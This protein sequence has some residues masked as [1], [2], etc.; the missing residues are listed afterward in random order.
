M[1]MDPNPPSFNIPF[2]VPPM[3]IGAGYAEGIEQA[4][5]S[6]AGAVGGVFDV[7][8]RNRT[9]NDTLQ[10]MN[11][12]GILSNDAYQSVAGKSLGA[13][14]QMMGMYAGQWIAQQAQN[15]ELQKLGYTGNVQVGVEHAK[16]LDTIN[17]VKSGYGAAAGVQPGKL[18]LGAQGQ[19]GA[20]GAPAAPVL[21]PLA[22]QGA[23]PLSN[24]LS[25]TTANPTPLGSAGITNPQLVNSPQLQASMAARAAQPV[26]VV[27]PLG[28]K[29]TIPNNWQHGTFKGQQGF[30]DPVKTEFHPLGQ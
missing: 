14:E 1:E 2:S 24:A 23:P 3:N 6:V 21:Q 12:N 15:R 13:K 30:F 28:P 18:Q 11:Q 5:K 29:D 26:T 19:S 7:M 10:A 22:G 25:G 4:G 20:A 17:A 8:N 27:K 16:L 9:V